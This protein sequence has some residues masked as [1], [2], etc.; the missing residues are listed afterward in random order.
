[1][2]HRRGEFLDRTP[3]RVRLHVTEIP[4]QDKMARRDGGRAGRGIS[5]F[6]ISGCLPPPATLLSPLAPLAAC[7]TTAAAVPTRE[8][9]VAARAAA[10]GPL[11]EIRHLR[12]LDIE[13]SF[14]R[15]WEEEH[16]GLN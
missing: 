3:L 7:A 11:A 2:A 9:V 6:R 13:V 15:L 14:G 4:L 10:R 5:P 16:A 12:G 8:T 1:M